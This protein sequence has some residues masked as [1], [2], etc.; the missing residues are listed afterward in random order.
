MGVSGM[1]MFMGLPEITHLEFSERKPEAIREKR[2][3]KERGG[4]AAKWRPS[5]QLCGLPLRGGGKCIRQL[6]LDLAKDD[7]LN[8]AVSVDW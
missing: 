2:G 5:D 8:R 4:L 7:D 1:Q 6:T 3:V